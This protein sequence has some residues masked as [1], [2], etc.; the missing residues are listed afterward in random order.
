MEH[1]QA[2]IVGSGAGAG[3]VMRFIGCRF[4]P[5]YECVLDEAAKRTALQTADCGSSDK[6]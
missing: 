3:W 4:L 2:E 6:G 5:V 1:E